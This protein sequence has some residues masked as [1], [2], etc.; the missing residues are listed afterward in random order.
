MEMFGLMLGCPVALVASIVWCL[1]A[2]WFLD[3]RVARILGVACSA[4]VFLALA[5]ELTLLATLGALAA[6]ERVPT[7]FFAVHLL[8]LV[9]LPPAVATTL[10]MLTRSTR[11]RRL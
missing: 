9:A 4:V 10:L 3:L 8:V 6:D 1:V 5:I 11:H 7:L 2:R